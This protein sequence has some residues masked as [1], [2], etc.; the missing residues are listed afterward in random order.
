MRLLLS[1]AV[2]TRIADEVD[3]QHD[4]LRIYRPP[5]AYLARVLVRGQWPEPEEPHTNRKLP[6][7][8]ALG[9]C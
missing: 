8:R 5:L 1:K 7:C 2:S 4:S 9:L 3:G 6:I